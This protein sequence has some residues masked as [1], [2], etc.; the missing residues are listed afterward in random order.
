MVAVVVLLTFGTQHHW[1]GWSRPGLLG[2]AAGASIVFWRHESRLAAAE[3]QPLVAPALLAVGPVRRELLGAFVFMACFGTLL[4]AVALYLQGHL[5]QSPLRS[6]LTFASYAVGFAVASLGWG[7]LPAGA[8]RFVP[9]IGFTLVAAS[10]AALAA[11]TWSG[12]WPAY[13]EG[14]LVI[15][16]AGHG[17]GYGALLRQATDSAGHEH[18]ATLSGVIAATSQLAIVMGAA[19][20]GTLYLSLHPDTITAPSISWVLLAIAGAATLAGATM[21]ASIRRVPR[22]GRRPECSPTEGATPR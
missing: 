22:H 6:G 13:A 11:A 10:A 16:G 7:R 5:H 2:L 9:R 17:G 12:G 14:L 1:P 4:F 19:G 18:A 3:G 20:G 15:T 8:H 21:A